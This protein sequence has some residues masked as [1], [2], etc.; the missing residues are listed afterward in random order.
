[1]YNNVMSTRLSFTTI[2][3]K[4]TEDYD[5][6]YLL[7]GSTPELPFTCC[8]DCG[9]QNLPIFFEG[10]IL[11]IIVHVAKVCLHATSP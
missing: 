5:I 8:A 9:L 11:N 2:L 6:G 3:C 7:D 1:M 10:S 4:E